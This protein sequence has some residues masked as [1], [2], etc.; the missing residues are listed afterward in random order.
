MSQTLAGNQWAFYQAKSVKGYLYEIQKEALELEVQQG[1]EKLSPPVLES[2]KAKIS[3]YANK[4][5]RYDTEKAAIQAQA[6][7]H[8]AIRDDA[9]AHAQIFGVAVVFLQV[10]ILLS[11][12]AALLKKPIVL[13]LGMAVGAVGIAHFANG[14]FLFF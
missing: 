12:I 10:A 11:S 2:Y 1:T 3:G 14:F 5:A 6:K 9:Q 8:E 7:N 13:Y 4:I